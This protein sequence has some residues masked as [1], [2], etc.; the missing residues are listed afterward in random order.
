M[1][2][3]ELIDPPP[4]TPYECAWLSAACG[5][6]S[7]A[8]G[9]GEAFN[10]RPATRLIAVD[11]HIIK[12]RTEYRL[13]ETRARRFVE[14]A[15]ARERELGI[16]HPHK[17]WFLWWPAPGET[18][19]G[20]AVTIGNV[21]PQL[22]ALNE[23]E[24]MPRRFPV[25]RRQALLGGMLDCFLRAGKQFD[26]SLD[27]CPSNFAVDA[28]DTLYYLDDD[29]Y[30]GAN[31]HVLSDALGNLLR[32]QDWL[33][34]EQAGQLGAALRDALTTHMEDEHWVTVVAEGVR[35]VFMPEARRGRRD[36]LVEAL[37]AGRTFNYQRRESS[38]VFALL[39]D[40][41]GNAP[42]LEC[43]LEYLQRR[44]I[45]TGIILGDVVGYGPHPAQC[46]DMLRELAGWM[47]LRGNHDHAIGSG[48]T[49]KGVSAMARW[50]L[51]WSIDTLDE[52]H[53]DWL[54][55]LPPYL[56]GEG[57]LAVHGSPIDKTFFN[58][59]VYQMSYEENLD[60]L[61]RRDIPLCFHGHTHIQK[62]YRR[63]HDGDSESVEREQNL[64][65]ARRAL[66]CPGSVGQPRGGEA[67][68]ELAIIDMAT[69]SLEF[70]RL[71]YDLDRTIADMTKL[72][73]P[74][75]LG[76]RLRQGQ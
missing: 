72:N 39:A 3:V 42:A 74:A 50:T 43:A 69:R 22:Q 58:G 59:Y 67:G 73:F 49:R 46:I 31:A 30:P 61:D 60:E 62:V 17:T 48:Q 27:L 57:W 21:T 52:S 45:D 12:F 76:E 6:Q 56:H 33:D 23:M 14:Q 25:Q 40:I 29:I 41:H 36:A 75:A 18:Q 19:A 51:D 47:L 8:A 54:M 32:S 65:E 71:S 24:A 9:H 16:H 11:G 64:Y 37:Y 10:G 66:V 15:V 1:S 38:P 35:G 63:D 20:H 5:R 34:E 26:V 4:G 13:D 44:G 2:N 53:R 70:H 68:V 28:T 55:N 7:Q